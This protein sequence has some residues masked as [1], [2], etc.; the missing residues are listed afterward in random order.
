MQILFKQTCKP[1]LKV[2]LINQNQ[3]ILKRNNSISIQLHISRRRLKANSTNC[4]QFHSNYSPRPTR[5][6][7]ETRSICIRPSSFMTNPFSVT[8]Y[9]LHRRNGMKT[10]RRHILPRQRRNTKYKSCSLKFLQTQ[11]TARLHSLR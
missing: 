6:Q 9:V 11:R 5:K 7:Q 8:R 3:N 2:V 1:M 4:L 10:F